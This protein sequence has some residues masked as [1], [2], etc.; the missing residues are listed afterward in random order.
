MK[1][2]YE[3]NDL[4][5]KIMKI[6]KKIVIEFIKCVK[7]KNEQKLNFIVLLELDKY[8]KYTERRIL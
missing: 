3:N 1:D 6:E 7:Q 5:K 8:N 2:D 4:K